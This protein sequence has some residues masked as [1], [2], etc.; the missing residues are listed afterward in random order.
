MQNQMTKGHIAAIFT[1]AIWS[2]TYISTKILLTSF[3]PVEIMVY[4]FIIGFIAL[5]LIAGK[6][7]QLQKKSHELLFVFAGICGV[8]LYFTLQN[9]ALTY[10]YASN[11]GVVISTAPFFTAIL[12]HL[13]LKNEERLH[14]SFFVGFLVAMA[15]I[16][17]ITFNG[18]KMELNPLGDLLTVLAAITWG[19]YSVFT[20]IINNLGYNNIKAIRKI[21]GYGLIFMIPIVLLMDIEFSP[22]K[23]IMPENI[24]H[25]V[26]L[27]MGAS[28]LCFITWNYAIK[29]LGTVKTSVYIYLEP[30]IT[31]VTSAWIL[32]E[33]ITP[34]AILGTI[35]TMAGLVLSEIKFKKNRI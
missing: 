34:L 22:Q 2:T 26:Y 35:L 13:L 19:F 3:D 31:V 5:L 23:L 32:H 14:V 6:P 18:A 21:F 17:L 10:T 28:A 30:V 20:K 16:I 8:A 4:R 7:M 27:G 25:I 9:V 29:V 12:T 24:F 33:I 15:G 1:V 11:T